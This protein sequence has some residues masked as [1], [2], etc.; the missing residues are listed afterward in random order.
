MNIHAPH[1][2][3]WIPI[4]FDVMPIYLHFIE[5][6]ISRSSK[7]IGNSIQIENEPSHRQS[8]SIERKSKMKKKMRMKTSLVSVGEKFSIGK[9]VA[10]NYLL[11]NDNEQSIRNFSWMCKLLQRNERKC[12]AKVYN[13]KVFV[14]ISLPFDVV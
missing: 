14:E 11:E 1:R 2:F 8:F 4:A 6:K 9:T 3:H 13:S 7:E 5:N 12:F 10:S